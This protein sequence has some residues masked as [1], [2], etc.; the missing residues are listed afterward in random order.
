MMPS[1]IILA[2][3]I[4]L[5]SMAVEGQMKTRSLVF[6]RATSTSYAEMVP[7][8]KMNLKAFTL[9]MTVATEL[10]GRREVLLFEYR[11]KHRDEMALWRLKDGRLGLFNGHKAVLFR[12][13]Q[14]KALH[15]HLCVSW[16]SA[17][18][19]TSLYVDGTRSLM[20]IFRKGYTLHDG[21][22]LIVGQDADSF[23]GRFD[24]KQS[25]VGELTNINMWDSA[26]PDGFI[27]EKSCQGPAGYGGNVFDWVSGKL[28]LHGE[29]KLIHYSV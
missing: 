19:A 26:L 27:S 24:A 29:A 12:V 9:C 14:L 22:K 15:T 20:K 1:P 17:N 10:T 23:L 6:S 2:S 28:K 3:A 18:G 8:R 13:P 11:T 4:L 7:M 25:F 21:G 5:L 16:N